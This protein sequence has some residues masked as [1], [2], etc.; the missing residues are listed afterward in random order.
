MKHSDLTKKEVD[1]FHKD[2]DKLVHKTFGHSSDEKKDIKNEMNKYGLTAKAINGKFY[3]YRNGK[4]T[5]TFNNIKDLQ[6]HQAELIQDESMSV[7]ED[8]VW[9]CA[10]QRQASDIQTK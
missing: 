3:S 9:M 8:H 10:L 1:K 6:K 5:G 4:L 2:L 7:K